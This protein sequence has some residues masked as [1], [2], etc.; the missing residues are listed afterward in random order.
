M[1]SVETKYEHIIIR[2]DGQ[3]IIEGNE[4]KVLQLVSEKIAY[5]WSPEEFHYQHPSLS[6]GQIHSALAYYWDH[7]EE[8][9]QQLKEQIERIDELRRASQ[10]SPLIKRLKSMGYYQ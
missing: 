5:G 10:S 6:L 3:A 9:N 2:E 8:L 4:M 7:Y 1:T